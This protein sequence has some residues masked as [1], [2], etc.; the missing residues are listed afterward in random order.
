MEGTAAIPRSPCRSAHRPP[1]V[2]LGPH[3]R[4]RQEIPRGSLQSLHKPF[5][6]H[7]PPPEARGWAHV[8]S[9]FGGR[10]RLPAPLFLE[11]PASA[12][13]WKPTAAKAPDGPSGRGGIERGFLRL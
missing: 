8:R 9:A 2:R 4:H 1:T 3:Y 10:E 11:F 6:N 12:A 7:T 13:A 5:S